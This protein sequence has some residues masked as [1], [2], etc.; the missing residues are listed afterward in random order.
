MSKVTDVILQNLE[1]LIFFFFFGASCAAKDD[2]NL[3]K[4]LPHQNALEISSGARGWVANYSPTSSYFHWEHTKQTGKIL[5]AKRGRRE[6]C[7]WVP[8]LLKADWRFKE[9]PE[10]SIPSPLSK[11]VHEKK[12]CDLCSLQQCYWQR[13]QKYNIL[14]PLPTAF[15]IKDFSQTKED[16]TERREE[17]TLSSKMEPAIGK[18]SLVGKLFCSEVPAPVK[19]QSVKQSHP[20]HKRSEDLAHSTVRIGAHFAFPICQPCDSRHPGL[21]KMSV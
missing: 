17:V 7:A 12:K 9:S 21:G 14:K 18:P 10:K 20:M 4:S 6:C 1:N 3:C 11:K 2:K 8:H 19:R 13:Q 5:A 16:G 15:R